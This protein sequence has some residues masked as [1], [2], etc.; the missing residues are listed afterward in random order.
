MKVIVT[1]WNEDG[2]AVVTESELFTEAYPG[3]IEDMVAGIEVGLPVQMAPN[4]YA[5]PIPVDR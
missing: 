4:V 5:R 2:E 1:Q 3:Q